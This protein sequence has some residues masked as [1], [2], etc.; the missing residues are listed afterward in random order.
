MADSLRDQLLKS[1]IVQQVRDEKRQQQPPPKVQQQR[2]GNKPAHA[3]G[4]PAPGGSRPVGGKGQHQRPPQRPQP[5]QSRPA[6]S[7]EIDLAKA[8]AIRAQAESAERK[9]VEQEA[10]ELARLRKERKVK[11]QQLLEGKALNKPDA[12]QARHF[13]YGA[14]IRRVH[15]DADQLVAIN[16]GQLGV[17][18]YSGRYLLFDRAIMD[19]VREI[20]P[21]QIALLVEPGESGNDDG[22]PDDLMW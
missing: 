16:A 18:Q 21:E 8:Y 12:D 9:R 10:A 22:V 17:V 6:S 20:A 7:G 1:G 3:V 2:T 19:Q 11:L 15:V 14:K 4:K 5:Q 13:E